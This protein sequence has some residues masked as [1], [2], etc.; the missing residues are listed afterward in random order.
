MSRPIVSRLIN[1]AEVSGRKST[2]DAIGSALGSEPRSCD[3]IL[4]GG[5]PTLRGSALS[6]KMVAH[7][8][9]EIADEAEAAALESARQAERSRQ[10]G[11]NARAAALLALRGGAAVASQGQNGVNDRL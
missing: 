3:A 2:R 1:H 6:A 7:R 11:D 9:E 4:A 10:I 5:K 8:L